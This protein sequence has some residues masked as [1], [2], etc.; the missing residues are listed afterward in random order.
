MIYKLLLFVAIYI[1]CW[2]I[3]AYSFRVALDDSDINSLK[4]D[5]GSYTELP[6]INFSNIFPGFLSVSGSIKVRFWLQL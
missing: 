4:F 6:F 3:L 5:A 1:L 2:C